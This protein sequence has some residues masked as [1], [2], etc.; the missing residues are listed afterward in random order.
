MFDTFDVL[1]PKLLPLPLIDVR[2]HMSAFGR[3]ERRYLYVGDVRLAWVVPVSVAFED[4]RTWAG[5]SDRANWTALLLRDEANAAATDDIAWAAFLQALRTI[6]AGHQEWRVTCESD[7][8]Q[9]PLHQL[10][11][12]A[13]ALVAL[14]GS[15]RDTSHFPIAFWAESQRPT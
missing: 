6:L 13:D 15:Y 7:C 14:L 2:Q 3:D 1:V 4:V 5:S 11:L 8:E 9:Y 12:T 10:S